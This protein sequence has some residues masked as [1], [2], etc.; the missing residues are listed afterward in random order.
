MAGGAPDA[1]RSST[2]IVAADRAG[3]PWSRLLTEGVLMTSGTEHHVHPTVN[4]L[5]RRPR[6]S[7]HRLDA[8]T[9]ARP[10][11]P[12]RFRRLVLPALVVLGLGGCGRRLRYDVDLRDARA[13]D[14]QVTL[15]LTGAP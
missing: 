3:S 4:A 12:R 9:H 1:A 11:L 7:V 14:L 8:A 13:G 15:H 5:D 10:R 2:V 6:R